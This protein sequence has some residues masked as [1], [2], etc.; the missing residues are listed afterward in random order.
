[1]EVKNK[2]HF[3]LVTNNLNRYQAN[4]QMKDVIDWILSQPGVCE[5]NIRNI[6][7]SGISVVD[8]LLNIIEESS[9]ELLIFIDGPPLLELS[10]QDLNRI[11]SKS[12]IA[13]FFG[14]IFAHFQ[15]S[16]KYFTQVI[17]CALVDESVEVGRFKLYGV[18]S[19]FVPY[20]YQ[21]KEIEE[22]EI[23]KKIPISFIGR[24]DRVGRKEYIEL[25]KKHFPITLYGVGT[26]NGPIK[27]EDMDVVFR[28]SIINLNFTGVQFYQPYSNAKPIDLLVKSAK[29]RCQEV[30]LRGGFVLS[31]NAPEI[32]KLFIPGQEIDIFDNHIE[33]LEKIDFY[34]KN[35]HIAA[36]IAQKGK[37]R[38][39]LNYRIDIVWGRTIMDLIQKAKVKKYNSTLYAKS[40]I[41]AL[42][43]ELKLS[44]SREF[45][46]EFKRSFK[47]INIYKIYTF[48]KL[49]GII[50]TLK[51]ILKYLQGR[52]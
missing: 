13:M 45:I 10:P 42:D 40:E 9:A 38:A 8:Y 2:N 27:N 23:T 30:A 22:N 6:F 5:L 31:E 49:I 37:L 20:A 11:R 19:I 26:Q 33:F 46:A 34:I 14:D 16:Y 15:S 12:Y 25:A 50:K 41:I 52:F 43:N 21:V 4:T 24:M 32:E 1:M 17:D 47:S 35:P 39:N 18:D 29:G 51:Y 28:S 36:N 7:L 3:I 48:V 44:I